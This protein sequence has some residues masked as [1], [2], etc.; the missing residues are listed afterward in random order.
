MDDRGVLVSF[1]KGWRHN[2][3]TSATTSK[4]LA[5]DSVA[6]GSRRSESECMQ[7]MKYGRR[8][9]S[10][11]PS[12]H[13]YLGSVFSQ[14]PGT[15]TRERKKN[16]RENTGDPTYHIIAPS[17]IHAHA[18]HCQTQCSRCSQALS[19]SL[20]IPRFFRLSPALSFLVTSTRVLTFR[21]AGNL[22]TLSSIE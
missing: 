21:L 19:L 16:K 4:T 6:R 12:K 13:T 11:C 20:S 9:P 15:R 18:F 1:H 3:P 17:E 10:C 5:T 8:R 2:Q 14:Q 22:L 7:L